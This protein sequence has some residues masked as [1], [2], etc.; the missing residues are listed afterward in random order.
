MTPINARVT[1]SAALAASSLL[2]AAPALAQTE[3]A[4]ALAPQSRPAARV[5]AVTGPALTWQVQ[6]GE[7]LSQIAARSG[8]SVNAI[9]GANR[10]EPSA[11]LRS[12]QALSIPAAVPTAPA[13]TLSHAIVSGD[14]L[15]AI[16]KRYGTTVSALMQ[17]NGLNSTT[18]RAG[19]TLVVPTGG[20]ST[21]AAAPVPTAGRYT[22]VRG[23]TLS[24]IAKRYGTTV[25]ALMQA[26]GLTSTTIFTGRTLTIPG[27]ATAPAPAAPKPAPAA[28]APAP[29]APAPAAPAKSGTHTIAS[30]DTLSAIAVRYGTTVSALMQANGLKSTTI[31]AGRTLV[32][33]GVASAPTTSQPGPLVS[34]TFLHYTYPQATVDA[35]NANK[36]ALLAA[37][38]PSR[39][40]MR[41]I[42][43]D[44]AVSMGVNPALALA[45]AFKESGFDHTAVSPANAIG[46]MQVIPSSGQWASDLVGRKL[47]LLDP[48][49]NVTA[50]VAILRQLV[51]TQSSLDVAIGSYYQGSGSIARNGMF[52]D[53]KAYVAG[54]KSLMAQFGG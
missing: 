17:A 26:N 44:T 43:R 54:V 37:G 1:L 31:F 16:A 51:R 6:A 28:S 14:T 32:I 12:G 9:A 10:L 2:G 8:A 33:P 47:N 40:Q 50:G 18:I 35:A 15:S 4:T 48:R 46:T 49:D 19:R 30:G 7:T 38:V 41:Q 3:G 39:E 11:P 29:A 52:S 27:T 34:N 24:T 21:P 20:P 13:P 23:D 5:A 45:I 42:V 36:A 53:T 22:I 25:S